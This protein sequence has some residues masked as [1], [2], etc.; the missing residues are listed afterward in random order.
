VGHVPIRLVSIMPLLPLTAAAVMAQVTP[1][2]DT[3]SIDRYVIYV[4]LLGITALFT[5]YTKKI[6]DSEKEWKAT[7]KESTAEFPKMQQTLD[8]AVSTL[9][10][11]QTLIDAQVREIGSLKDVVV[12]IERHVEDLKDLRYRLRNGDPSPQRREGV[13]E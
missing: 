1:P 11:Q 12:R 13:G 7:A 8:K 4:L 6:L 5:L 10:T 9:T 3:G 2:P